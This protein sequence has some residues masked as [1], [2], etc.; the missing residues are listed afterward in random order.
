MPNSVIAKSRLENRSAPTPTRGVTVSVST[1]AAID[2]RR[3]VAAL[4]AAVRACWLPLAQPKPTINC[5]GLQGDGIVY[6]MHFVVGATGDIASARTEMLSKVHRHLR[7]A[8]I[9]LS[10]SG[11]APL[12]SASVPTI[13]EV[14]AEL[15]LFGPLAP[16]ERAL[17]G[18]HFV[19]VE[20]E[21][22][23]TLFREGEIPDALF[24]LA[25]G[26]VELT[27]GEGVGE[28]AVLRSSP[29]DSVGML[30][31]ITGKAA[32][33]TATAL[34][35]VTA[36]SLGKADIA[37]VVR[38]RPGLATSLEAQAKRGQSWLR[39]EVAA[40]E[41]EQIEKPGMLLSGLRQ[42]LQRLNA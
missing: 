10:V 17:L 31:L 22:G 15:D 42:F 26:T 13:A 25:A 7:H 5:V 4:E 11:I 28:K 35:P 9:S 30:A 14:M 23:E 1:D 8:G 19:V 40:H 37:K 39:C 34:T 20:R 21:A 33:L 38:A 18:E 41:N 36:Y 2:P 16:D 12:P 32:L 27:R 24:L 3:C 29:G 6:E